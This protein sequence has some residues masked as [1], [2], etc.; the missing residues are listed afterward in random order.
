MAAEKTSAVEEEPEA[1]TG[2]TRFE[3]LGPA[4]RRLD[5][6]IERALVAAQH[7]YGPDAAADAFRGLHISQQEIR[8]LLARSP[9]PRLPRRSE[10]VRGILA[11]A[12][13]EWAR[14]RWLAQAF[15]L[16]PFDLGCHSDRVG[17]GT[18]SALRAAIRLS[19]GT[20]CRGE[21]LPWIWRSTCSAHPRTTRWRAARTSVPTRRSSTT[22]CCI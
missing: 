5:L 14:L 17:A 19:P 15:G 12:L 20:T 1:S 16:A 13:C 18:G 22:V 2:R 9:G 10:R 8:R 7:A 3:D 4:L 21:G 11:G 6:L